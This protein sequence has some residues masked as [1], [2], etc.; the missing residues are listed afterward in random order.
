MKGGKH[1]CLWW[2]LVGWWWHPVKLLIAKVREPRVSVSYSPDLLWALKE[3]AQMRE[4][5]TRLYRARTHD[6]AELGADIKKITKGKIIA[7]AVKIANEL[8]NA[9]LTPLDSPHRVDMTPCKLTKTGKVPKCIANATASF[10]WE[11]PNRVVVD[12]GYLADA[13]PYKAHILM[14]SGRNGQ[15]VNHYKARMKDGKLAI[16]GNEAYIDG[17]EVCNG[18]V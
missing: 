10:R 2:L 7:D 1:G 13:T 9:K 16:V 18:A 12:I 5:N 11:E 15:K 17:I 4:Q 14:L 6:L 3:S 8:C